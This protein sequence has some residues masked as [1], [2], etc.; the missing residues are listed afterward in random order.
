[1][2]ALPVRSASEYLAASTQHG[3]QNW[4]SV[5]ELSLSAISFRP[6]RSTAPA[7][8][9]GRVYTNLRGRCKRPTKRWLQIA[10]LQTADQMSS[11]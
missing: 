6:P 2:G 11:A 3:S 7:P 10:V 4:V 5:R 9:R 8:L 1:M